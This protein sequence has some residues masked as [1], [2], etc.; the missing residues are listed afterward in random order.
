MAFYTDIRDGFASDLITTYGRVATLRQE[1]I[2]YT[3]ATGVGTSVDVDTTIYGVQVTYL[4]EQMAERGIN[5]TLIEK[6]GVG[7]IV[8][9][10]ETAAAS[11]VPNIND[12]I[13]IGSVTHQIVWMEAI[14]PGGTAVAYKLALARA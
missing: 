5:R 12:K 8:S 3:V 4:R 1:T 6:V 9:A 7:F 10:K 11:V 14:E 2:T 13:I